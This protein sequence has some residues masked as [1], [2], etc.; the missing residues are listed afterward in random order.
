MRNRLY[1]QALLAYYDQLDRDGEPAAAAE[2]DPAAEQ[3]A[4]YTGLE[5]CAPPRRT[6]RATIA[7]A[8]PW[9]SFAAAL[10]SAVPGFSVLPHLRNEGARVDVLLAIDA[11]ESAACWREQQPTALVESLRS[12][13]EAAAHLA[14]IAAKAARHHLP[15]V[16]VGF[17][18]LSGGRRPAA[19]GPPPG[20]APG[21]PPRSRDCRA[22]GPARGDRRVPAR[23]AG[24]PEW[25]PRLNARISARQQSRGRAQ[26][27]VRPARIRRSTPRPYS[28]AAYWPP[29]TWMV[30]PVSR[31]PFRGPKGDHRRQLFRPADALHG[32]GR[33]CSANTSLTSR[34]SVSR[35]GCARLRTR[36]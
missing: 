8:R 2:G 27:C 7:P 14:E 34:P 30:A 11:Q 35:C 23:Q 17:H 29:S 16:F 3:E 1:R 31:P 20:T 12:G 18:R 24:P 13:P 15:L 33:L 19:A 22:V 5:T 28:K 21:D 36:S 9:E 26:C 10:F 6:N 4:M 25:R 32:H